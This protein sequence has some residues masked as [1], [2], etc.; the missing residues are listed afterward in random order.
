MAQL[1]F[2]YFRWHYSR[3]LRD[4]MRNWTNFI[5][6]FWHFFSIG[7][8]AKTFFAPLN[9]I[10]EQS[11]RAGIHVEE[12]FQNALV[13]LIMR[14]VGMLIRFLF[15]VLGFLSIAATLLLGGFFF[16]VWLCMPLVL[17]GLIAA[18]VIFFIT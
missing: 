11:E 1:A 14:L 15:I 8:L 4:Y 3:G 12:F 2:Y 6:F 7:L 16:F 18:G 5:W 13:N 10:H 9:R 17:L